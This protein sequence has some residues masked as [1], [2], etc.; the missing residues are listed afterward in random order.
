MNLLFIVGTGRCGSTLVHEVL[1]RHPDCGFVSNIEDN[2]PMVNQLGRWNNALYRSFIGQH[3]KKGR[4]RFA[5]SEAYN[6]MEREISP[7][8]ANSSRDL[9]AADVTPWLQ[10]KFSDFFQ[11]RAEAQALPLFTHKYTGW[12]R[13]GFFG[14]IFPQAKFIHI[15][16]DGRAVANSWLQMDWWL[17]YRGPE[18]WHWGP[19]DEA[20]RAEWRESGEDF[21]VLAGI[22]WKK[23]M[24]AFETAEAQLAPE[25]YL[26]LR[27]EDIVE[28]P[29]VHFEKMLQFS[30]LQ[31]N[32]EF[33][34]GFR[35]QEFK[36]NRRRAFEQDLNAAQLE[37]LQRNLA[38]MLQKFGYE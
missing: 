25:N 36:L 23:L 3:T 16:R 4:P 20:E 30:G 33:E 26:R 17:G 38:P 9:H 14:K 6:L 22:A 28:S 10:T 35:R 32:E 34:Q 2:V 19:L 27:F 11:R 37:G 1:G 15:V 5:P 21:A 8:Y 31:W 12:P 7:I 29:R 18:H 24:R 13:L